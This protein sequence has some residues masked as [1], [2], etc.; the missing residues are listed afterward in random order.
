[1]LTS[2]C[3]VVTSQCIHKEDRGSPAKASE[4][5]QPSKETNPQKR[6]FHNSVCPWPVH[7]N[8]LPAHLLVTQH[9]L[10]LVPTCQPVLT[11]ATPSAPTSTTQ[12]SSQVERKKWGRDKEVP[13]AC[14]PPPFQSSVLQ[15]GSCRLV[16]VQLKRPFL[17][18]D[19][20]TTGPALATQT[21]A[22]YRSTFWCSKL[23]YWIP[24]SN[25]STRP[26]Q[27]TESQ[28]NRMAWVGRNLKDHESPTLPPATGRASNLHI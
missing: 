12:H 8:V 26:R 22:W 15:T 23:N 10:C 18:R 28:N 13:R 25:N 9:T 20:S 1:M 6:W 7:Q 17:C 19:L 2:L 14:R 24:A 5:H 16:A 3:Q 27:F 4:K 11:H 21:H